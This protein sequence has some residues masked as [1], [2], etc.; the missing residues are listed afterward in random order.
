[1]PVEGDATQAGRRGWGSALGLIVLTG[2]SSVVHSA[3]LIFL[4]LALMLVALP[5]RRL[6]H[7]AVG[8]AGALFLLWG[9]T[10][11]LTLDFGRGWALLLAG[12]FLVM[13]VA[14]GSPSFLARALPAVGATVLTAGGFFAANRGSLAQLDAAIR[15]EMETGLDLVVGLLNRAGSAPSETMTQ[16]LRERIDVQMLLYPAILAIAS[17]AGLA[18][19]WWA[20]RRLTAPQ[21]VALAPLREFRFSDGLV[22][23]FIAGLL[24]MWLPLDEVARRAGSNL[25]AFTSVLYALR[26]LAVMVML[27]GTPGPFGVIASVVVAIL[28]FPIVMAATF[29]VGLFD[30]WLEFRTRWRRPPAST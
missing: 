12:W 16:A 27:L 7:M 24:L 14:V 28:L 23:L 15:T 6:G 8:V 18:V 13:S 10:G 22:W 19:A 30:T 29:V 5:P 1:L 4:P 21:R 2:F 11:Q 17:L 20:F 26:G 3:L 9:Q 25:L